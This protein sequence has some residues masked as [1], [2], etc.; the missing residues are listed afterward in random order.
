MFPS[1]FILY[2]SYCSRWWSDNQN[3]KNLPCG[4][5]FSGK[6]TSV[7]YKDA[8]WASEIRILSKRESSLGNDVWQKVFM[9]ESFAGVDAYNYFIS[10]KLENPDAKGVLYPEKVYRHFDFDG[11]IGSAQ[12]IKF[13][14]FEWD[15]T[16]V[17][18]ELIFRGTGEIENWFSLENVLR[19]SLWNFQSF[20][21]GNVGAFFQLVP[22]SHLRMYFINNGYGGC[23][24]DNG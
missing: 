14:V 8:Q 2:C 10:G 9:M 15:K 21:P 24:D 17:V 7:D 23:N 11:K 6:A 13:Q 18:S 20:A 22:N 19:S 3:L 16:T 4:F 1:C 12:F 5:L